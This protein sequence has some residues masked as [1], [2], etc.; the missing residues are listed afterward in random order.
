MKVP[1]RP[2]STRSS[3]NINS[4][5]VLPEHS[6]RALREIGVLRQWRRGQVLHWAGDHPE[7]I[8]AVQKGLLRISNSDSAGNENILAWL[9]PGMVGA[10]AP[11]IANQP[12]NFNIVA[13]CQSEV[14][15]I[16]RERLLEHI[17][18]DSTTALAITMLLSSRLN[19]VLEMFGTQAFESLADKVWAR[20]VQLAMQSR[21]NGTATVCVEVTQADLARSVG[22]SRYRVGL[23]LNRLEATGAIAL[24]RGRI[25]IPREQLKRRPRKGS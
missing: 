18:R 12:F 24:S 20:L 14:L 22:G 19:N 3:P 13:N 16:Q 5:E 10:L 9:E 8:L 6:L 21:Q 25:E 15:H 2:L 1:A 7:S 17:G 23:E 11:V 4:L